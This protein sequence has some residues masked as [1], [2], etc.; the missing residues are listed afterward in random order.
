[1]VTRMPPRGR[2]T[3]A[4]LGNFGLT[5][6]STTL[7]LVTA[8]VL[9]QLLG[10]AGLGAF[11]FAVALIVLLAI[12]AML[13]F[14]SVVIR[15]VSA[16][17]VDG[18]LGLARGLLGRALRVVLVTS[19]A[20]G[21]VAGVA[22]LWLVPDSD[23][24]QRAAL[25]ALV[26]VPLVALSRLRSA[27]LS[28]LHHPVAGNVPET[29]VRPV[30]FLALT[31]AVAWSG[32]AALDAPL[33]AV[34]HVVAAALAFLAG[35]Y[36]LAR[37]IPPALRAATASYRTREWVRTALSLTLLTLTSTANT[38]GPVLILGTLGGAHETGL[39]AVA[40]RAATL[41][42][43]PLAAVNGVLAPT[44][45]RLWAAGEVDRL[46]QVVTRAT[47][48]VL[49]VSAPA[50]LALVALGP[51]VLAWFGA[52]FVAAQPALAVLS[53][54]Q[55]VNAAAGSVGMLLIMTGRQLRAASVVA[56]ATALNLGLGLLLVPP[57]GALGAAIGTAISL[58][59]W[60]VLLAIA[61][62]RELRID[63]SAL[64]IRIRQRASGR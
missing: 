18:E 28:G 20:L 64:G 10:A 51:V 26:A 9:G 30:A 61:V 27:A 57:L 39:F 47:R 16:Y 55:F 31:L 43:L 19:V 29:V 22:V 41:I 1:M 32:S 35:T 24:M 12:V 4:V 5:I 54:G 50:A 7:N 2:L 36:L 53:V 46:Q 8:L 49:V 38:H 63:P 23:G 45:A 44:I 62:V 34:L 40:T 15:L 59:T 60:N 58:T 13:G 17:E 56:F 52:E 33:A 14:D 48:G 11:S 42:S 3:R 21:L 6:L 37:R 25:I